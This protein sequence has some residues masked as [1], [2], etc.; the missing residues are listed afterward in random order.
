MTSIW[1]VPGV[2][3]KPDRFGALAPVDVLIDIDGPRLFTAR[4]A[5]DETL[6]V[7]QCAEEGGRMAWVAVPTEAGLV[8][9]LREGRLPL[10]DALRQPWGWLITQAFDGTIERAVRVRVDDLPA[11][12]LPAPGV[13]LVAPEPPFLAVRAIG[14]AFATGSEVPMS[15]VRKVLDG[16]MHAMKTLVEHA[17]AMTSSDGRPTENLR[18]YYDLPARR[19]A[20]GS[21]EAVFGE[22][23]APAARPLLPDDRDA[24]DRAGRVLQRGLAELHRAPDDDLAV[25]D[26]LGTAL[27]ALSG[28]LPPASGLIEEMQLRGRLVGPAP[29]RL[30][31]EHGARVRRVLRRARAAAEPLVVKGAIRE[32]D[33][34]EMTFILRS[35]DL[36]E[37]WA[38]RYSPAQRDD[39]LTAFSEEYP[40]AV[41]GHRRAPRTEIEVLAIEPLG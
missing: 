17:L 26:E 10:L 30:S 33:K 12:A 15:V 9:A 11:A 34:D 23:T 27:D 3:T 32:L 40:V 7:Y 22:P 29:V 28:L 36:Q 13:T 41:S 19:L 25:D 39:V 21:F 1:K 18:R 37:Q 31:R 16:A 8:D 14:S 20:F 24:L 35:Q 2:A 38:C 4:T 5:E 6:L